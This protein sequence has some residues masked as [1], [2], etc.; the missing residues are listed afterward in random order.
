MKRILGVVLASAVVCLSACGATEESSAGRVERSS[1]DQAGTDSR[2]H[3]LQKLLRLDELADKA[4]L[5]VR[6]VVASEETQSFVESPEAEP[7]NYVVSVLD[8]TEVLKGDEDPRQVEVAHSP[9]FGTAADGTG[10]LVSG[11]HHHGIEVGTEYVLFLFRG[12]EVWGNRYLLLGDQ[13]T[14]EVDQGLVRIGQGPTMTVDDL[15]RALSDDG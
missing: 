6:G 15:A 11:G 14:A 7:G 2:V 10:S 5:V 9:S 8:V 1:H 13:G 4:D 12:D 3:G